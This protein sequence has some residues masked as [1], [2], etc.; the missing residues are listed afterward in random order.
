MLKHD[1]PSVI[2]RLYPDAEALYA[3]RGWQLP[4]SIGRVYD[5]DLA[6]RELGFRCRTDFAAILSALRSRER[7]PFKDDP[8]YVS[9]KNE[10]LQR[11]SASN[12]LRLA[13]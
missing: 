11:G 8:T 12:A 1:A 4:K 13:K 5:A 2:T 3:E 7:L 10:I 6:E 9:P